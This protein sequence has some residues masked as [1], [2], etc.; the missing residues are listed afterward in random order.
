MH[1]RRQQPR[2][3]RLEARG[4][5]ADRALEPLRQSLQRLGG[6]RG[7]QFDDV[8]DQFVGPADIAADQRVARRA[9]VIDKDA[10]GDRGGV[11]RSRID[12]HVFEFDAVGHGR[13][14][15]GCLKRC[16]GTFWPWLG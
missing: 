6:M 2:A 1:R 5:L 10:V 9:G 13:I 12:D 4:D 3:V 16:R 8:A 7:L 15:V 14:L 11:E